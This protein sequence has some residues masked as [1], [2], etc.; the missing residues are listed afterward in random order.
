MTKYYLED[1]QTGAKQELYLNDPC[2]DDIEHI[3]FVTS[4]MLGYIDSLKLVKEG[5]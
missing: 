4:S 2:E 3:I 1:V 5:E